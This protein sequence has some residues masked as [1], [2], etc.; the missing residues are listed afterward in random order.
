[1][2]LCFITLNVYMSHLHSGKKADTVY[3]CNQVEMKAKVSCYV[4]GTRLIT[5]CILLFL[6]SLFPP[7]A[8]L[9]AHFHTSQV[10]LKFIQGLYTSALY[11]TKTAQTGKMLKNSK[12]S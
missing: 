8:Q 6:L 10:R 5:S 7:V 9:K 2:S 12:F 1:M 4:C 11:L 3:G